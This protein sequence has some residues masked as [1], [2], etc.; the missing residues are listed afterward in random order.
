M[1]MEAEAERLASQVKQQTKQQEEQGRLA[2]S[3]VL[4]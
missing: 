4:K 3:I 1:M 2:A